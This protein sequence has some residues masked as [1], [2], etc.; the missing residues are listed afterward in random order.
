V[1]EVAQARLRGERELLVLAAQEAE[2]PPHLHQRLLATGLDRAQRLGDAGLADL[3]LLGRLGLDDDDADAVGDDVVQLARDAR[4]LLGH[5][6]AR[7]GLALALDAHGVGLEVVGRAWRLR[8]PRP[9]N[10]LPTTNTPVKV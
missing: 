3:E 9:A 4:S 2:Q 6:L 5:G 10:Q 7:L 1:V 8:I